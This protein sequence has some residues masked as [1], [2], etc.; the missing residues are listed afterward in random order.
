MGSITENDAEEEQIKLENSEKDS[1]DNFEYEELKREVRRKHRA[2]K[3]Q[4]MR[5]YFK[6]KD[7]DYVVIINSKIYGNPGG[8]IRKRRCRSFGF[9]DS[10]ADIIRIRFNPS[11]L[12][13]ISSEQEWRT[14][15]NTF[16]N[17][18]DVQNI[19]VFDKHKIKKF[20]SYFKNKAAND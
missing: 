3:K 1:E 13:D 7:L 8:K 11:P 20:L 17:Y 18:Q 12:Y 9:N 15:V 2:I 14:F 10:G 16:D 4:V 19:Y 5:R 6:E